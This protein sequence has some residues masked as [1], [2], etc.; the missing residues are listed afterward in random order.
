[1]MWACKGPGMGLNELDNACAI[2]MLAH[3]EMENFI[4]N[5]RKLFHCLR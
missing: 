5:F 2:V 3:L 4:W 1:M